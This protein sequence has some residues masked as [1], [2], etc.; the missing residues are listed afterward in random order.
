MDFATLFEEQNRLLNRINLTFKRS[1]YNILLS[2]KSRFIAILGQRGVGKT[3]LMLQFIKEKYF[4]DDRV[5]YVSVDTPYFQS[6]SLYDFAKNFEKYGGEILFLDE[7]HK[8]K[9]FSIHLKAIYD[10]TDLKV[11]VSGSSLL[12]IY[13]SY[14]DLSRRIVTY[15]LPNLSF[16]EYLELTGFKFPQIS[17]EELLNNHTN[18]AKEISKNIKPLKY[19]K[20]Y[21]E[22]GAY[23]F[24]I[25]G[26]EVYKLK[27]INIINHILEVDLPYV[28]SISHTNIEKIK[29]LIYLIATSVPFTPNIS[30]LSQKTE[31][32]RPVIVEYLKHLENAQ[33]IFNM[34]FQVR[35]YQKLR[36]PD[37]IYLNNTNLIRAITLNSKI[38]SE[39]ET[40]FVNQIINYFHNTQRFYN[41]N[42]L[43]SKQGDFIVNNTIFEIGGK[44]KTSKQIKGI[45]NS[46]VVVDDI[47]IGHKNKI[48]LWLFGFLY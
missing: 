7:I 37:K 18:Y 8:L 12:Q 38:G 46:Y 5:L 11:I 26:V 15:N 17:F 36:K 25:E 23:P 27:L 44:N 10:S 1:F 45:E 30:E 35:G 21:L 16:R 47:E 31:I 9:D 22:Y 29:K 48:P 14:S 28:T 3:T 42:I 34:H 43:L 2:N 32:S 4:N 41:E 13:K 6:V 19:F 39:R 20:N 24:V 33:L 40:F